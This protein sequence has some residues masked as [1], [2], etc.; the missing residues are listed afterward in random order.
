MLHNVLHSTLTHVGGLNPKAFRACKSQQKSL[1][2]SAKSVVDGDLVFAF[3][4]LSRDQQVEVAR[5]IGTKV[6]ELINDFV[7]I[8]RYTAHF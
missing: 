5:K 8:D 3:L 6:E 2:N 4:S 7:E 1:Q